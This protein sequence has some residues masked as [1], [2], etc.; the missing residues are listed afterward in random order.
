VDDIG[1]KI[2][3][4][5]RGVGW[6]LALVLVFIAVRGNQVGAVAGAI[7]A[8]FALR[9]A[10]DGADFFAF[11]RAEPDRFAFFTDGTRHELSA[12]LMET[13]TIRCAIEKNKAAAGK[14]G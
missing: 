14:L 10:T 9:A 2:Y 5:Q 3:V 11:G 6:K 13:F 8:D 4:E 1:R 12:A 7:D